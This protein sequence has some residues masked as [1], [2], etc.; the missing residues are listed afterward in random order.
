MGGIEWKMMISPRLFKTIIS[1]SACAIAVTVGI[2]FVGAPEVGS[3]YLMMM[4]SVGNH[5]SILTE[6]VS[7]PLL[8]IQAGDPHNRPITLIW[9]WAVWFVLFAIPLISALWSA[10]AETFEQAIARWISGMSVFGALAVLIV[11]SVVIGLAL[12][13]ACM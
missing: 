1:I 5:F 6:A 8:R 9:V 10:R 11:V 7:L 2:A 13:L 4:K 3:A 12:P